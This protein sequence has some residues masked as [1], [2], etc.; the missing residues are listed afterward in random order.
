MHVK[1]IHLYDYKYKVKDMVINI[2]AQLRK[3]RSYTLSE[4]AFNIQ[5]SI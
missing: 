5:R 1:N 3:Y 4:F 2:L